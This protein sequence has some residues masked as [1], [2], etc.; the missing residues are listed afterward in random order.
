MEFK[1][2]TP[3]FLLLSMKNNMIEKSKTLLT[4]HQC[5][6][7][8]NKTSLNS[9]RGKKPVLVVGFID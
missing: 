9:I 4:G 2:L 1:S 8:E 6:Q 7:I 3:V 5:W